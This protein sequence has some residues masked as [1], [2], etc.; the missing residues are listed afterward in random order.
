MEEPDLLSQLRTICKTR[1]K[2]RLKKIECQDVE[3]HLPRLVHEANLSYTL[4]TVLPD[5][6]ASLLMSWRVV[7]DVRAQ[8]L[9]L[10]E[11]LPGMC[12]SILAME[13]HGGS[14]PKKRQAESQPQGRPA[15]RATDEDVT[16]EEAVEEEAPEAQPEATNDDAAPKGMQGK[17]HFHLLIYYPHASAPALDHSYA[18]REIKKLFPQADINQV[19]LRTSSKALPTK[20]I[21]GAMTYVLKGAGCPVLERILALIHPTIPLVR[22]TLRLGRE[23]LPGSG[24]GTILRALTKALTSTIIDHNLQVDA[25]PTIPATYDSPNHKVSRETEALM[26]VSSKV[27]E[28][29]LRLKGDQFYGLVSGTRFTWEVRGNVDKLMSILSAE[30]VIF[31]DYCV[32]YATKM[33]GWFALSQFPSLPSQ[34]TYRYIEL[35]D[36]VY[37][38]RTG[39]YL[40]K[41]SVS[42]DTTMCFRYYDINV[43]RSIV[44]EPTQWLSLIRYAHAFTANPADEQE[45]FVKKMARLLRARRP[46]EPIMFMLGAS[47]SGKSTAVAWITKF[48]PPAAICTI[49]DSVAPLSAVKGAEILLCDEFSTHKISRSNLLLLTDGTTGLTVRSFGRGAEYVTDV[50]LPQ[51]YTANVGHE[52]QYKNDESGALFNRFQ[53]FRWERAILTPDLDK[54]QAIYEETPFIVFYLNRVNAQQ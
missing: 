46:K 30:D 24:P 37:S 48:Y 5:P 54:A 11:R 7:L 8:L 26:V 3:S 10:V 51:I 39:E 13:V 43:Y 25:L 42:A 2:D 50:D 32:R 6:T 47:N 22:P 21:V 44:T 19:H 20:K 52:P 53:F 15:R 36:A 34:Y 14:R 4:V 49:N 12:F 31:L 33:R 40:D 23:F 9:D 38:V 29:G 17:P 18:K 35:R 41:D 1:P 45:R 16:M 27:R 28:L